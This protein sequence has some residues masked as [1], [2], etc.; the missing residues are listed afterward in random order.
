MKETYN[1]SLTKVA[2]K[3]VAFSRPLEL[4]KKRGAHDEATRL[5]VSPRFRPG[6]RYAA[7][8]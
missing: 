1:S 3:C 2:Q 5:A 4:M 6:E 7:T 8:T